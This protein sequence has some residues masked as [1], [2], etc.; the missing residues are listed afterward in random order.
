MFSKIND[1]RRRGGEH[2]GGWGDAWGEESEVVFEMEIVLFILV[3]SEVDS[4]SQEF[5]KPKNS[6]VEPAK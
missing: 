3:E 6:L 2:R 1:G 5:I 4:I